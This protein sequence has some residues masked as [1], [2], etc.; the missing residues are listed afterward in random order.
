MHGGKKKGFEIVVGKSMTHKALVVIN[1]LLFRVS[2]EL[3]WWSVLR[4]SKLV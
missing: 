1:T 3:K 4:Y 2:P